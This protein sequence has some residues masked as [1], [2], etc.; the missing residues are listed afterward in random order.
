MIEPGANQPSF[1]TRLE[2][3]AADARV[4][5]HADRRSRE[6]WLEQAATG[7]AT[8][9]GV[10]IDLAERGQRVQLALATGRR[11]VGTVDGLGADFVAVRA[12]PRGDVLVPFGAIDQV[13]A[14][15]DASLAAE[16]AV[17]TD[18]R[19]A[20]VLGAMATERERVR[21]VG[22]DPASTVAGVLRHGGLDVV[23]IR[24]DAT[25]ATTVAIPVAALSEVLLA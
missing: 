7:D 24:T 13:A 1:S 11:V 25:P 23:T 22:R 21:V 6:R 12:V 10:L 8:F 14:L 16:R 18:L 5:E 17:A 15:D 3:W 20:D 9:A 4:D 2:R 19:L